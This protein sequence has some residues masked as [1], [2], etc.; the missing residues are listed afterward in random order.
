MPLDA[1]DLF[2]LVDDSLDCLVV[3]V[4]EFG[5]E[6]GLCERFRGHTVSMVLSSD[7][8]SAGFEIDTGMV[9]GSVSELQ[10]VSVSS[11]S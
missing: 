4:D 2:G 5:G 11:C 7:I 6:L 1:D 8:A 9:N 10:L 3:Y